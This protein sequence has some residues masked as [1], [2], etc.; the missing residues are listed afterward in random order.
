MKVKH[1]AIVGLGSIGRRHLRLL[2]ELRPQLEIT[3]VRSGKGP[4]YPEVELATRTVHSLNDAVRSGI[5]VAIISSPT[6][7][8]L[9]QALMLGRAGIH[10]LLEKPL[11]H[12]LD[13]VDELLDQIEKAKN[14][15]LIGYVLRY[16]PG[17]IKFNEILKKKMHWPTFTCSGRMRFLFA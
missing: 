5:Q 4:D 2:K 13:G 1:V 7:K 8:H 6:S 12:S 16:A 11:S 10:L 17:A 14:I 9:M 15:S 3:L